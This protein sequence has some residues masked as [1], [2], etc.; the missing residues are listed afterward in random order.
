MGEHFVGNP[1]PIAMSSGEVAVV[2]V[3][4]SSAIGKGITTGNGIVFSNDDGITWGKDIDISRGFGRANGSMPGPGAGVELTGSHRLLVV[5][6]HGPYVDDYIS[7]SDDAGRSWATLAHA[8]PKMD[9]ASL[10][11]LGGGNVLL[12]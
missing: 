8:F 12:N 2:Y 10:A 11:D 3:N 6:H 7:Y 1:Y 4:H 5:S 9:E